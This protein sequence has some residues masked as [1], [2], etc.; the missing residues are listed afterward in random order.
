MYM[1]CERSNSVNGFCGVFLGKGD[2]CWPKGQVF[3]LPR[4]ILLIM[5]AVSSF[6][7]YFF[8]GTS[9]QVRYLCVTFIQSSA[10]SMSM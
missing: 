6:M 4:L 10:H 5:S 8:I 1:L 3:F 7:F 9:L 2:N